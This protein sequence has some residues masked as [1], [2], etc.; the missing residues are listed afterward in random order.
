MDSLGNAIDIE[1]ISRQTTIHTSNSFPSDPPIYF[2]QPPIHPNL[3][4]FTAK[5]LAILALSGMFTQTLARD[6]SVLT[7]QTGD[8]SNPRDGTCGFYATYTDGN[9]RESVASEGSTPPTCSYKLFRK[10]TNKAGFWHDFEIFGDDKGDVIGF[11][12]TGKKILLNGKPREKL[13]DPEYIRGRCKNEFKGFDGKKSK[14]TGFE[15]YYKDLEE[16]F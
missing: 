4:S 12:P 16:L 3:F 2:Q 1:T 8:A 11:N 15:L 5:T 10:H 9:R 14:V 7:C 13:K 6:A